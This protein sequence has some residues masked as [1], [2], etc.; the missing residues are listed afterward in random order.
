MCL[1]PF[2]Y[3]AEYQCNSKRVID[4]CVCCWLPWP[5]RPEATVLKKGVLDTLTC[6]VRKRDWM[7]AQ[8]F[9]FTQPVKPNQYTH[10]SA[11]LTSWRL[12]IKR[13]RETHEVKCII[14]LPHFLVKYL[15]PREV[16]AINFRKKSFYVSLQLYLL[17]D[18]WWIPKE[19]K[20]YP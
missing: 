2:I 9:W 8:L 5:S 20:E 12:K 10:R 1:L 16:P 18:H 4:S 13:Y 19:P 15:D 7:K 17:T 3:N 6:F 14:R 11:I